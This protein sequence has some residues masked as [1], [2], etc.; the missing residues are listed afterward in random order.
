MQILDAVMEIE[1]C[2]AGLINRAFRQI[3]DFTSAAHRANMQCSLLPFCHKIK[4]LS[5]TFVLR[6][7]IAFHNLIFYLYCENVTS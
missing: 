4:H 3:T 1:A 2:S 6:N 7:S 5:L